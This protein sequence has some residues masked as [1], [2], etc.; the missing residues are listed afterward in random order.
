NLSGDPTEVVGVLP[1][2]FDFDSVFT[3]GTKVELLVPLQMVKEFPNEGNILFGIGR[4]KPNVTLRQAQVEFDVINQRLVKAHPER[5]G[6]GGRMSGLETSI[7]GAF[8][9]PM[10]MLFVAVGCVLLIACFNLSNLLLARANAR[11]KEFA[12]RA[13]LGATR[14]HLTRQTLTESL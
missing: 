1:A 2:S 8:R 9:Q 7:R 4:L 3:P 10:L 13:A 6:F 11:R 14:W 12:V 5:G